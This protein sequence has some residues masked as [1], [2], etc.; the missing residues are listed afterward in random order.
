[1]AGSIAKRFL[2]K[3]LLVATTNLE[4]MDIQNFTG[5]SVSVFSPVGAVGTVTLQAS[6]DGTH[7]AS[8]GGAS[9]ALVANDV[10]LINIQNSYFSLV[11]AQIVVSAGPGNY[12]IIM[13]GKER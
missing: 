1:M 6:N 12:D 9:T 8:I 7:W 5:C 4:P 3:P 2:A 10:A 13:I 11:R